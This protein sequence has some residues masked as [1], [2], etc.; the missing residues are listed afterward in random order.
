ML[1]SIADLITMSVFLSI[2]PSVR[3]A[4]S[5]YAR[6]DKKGDFMLLHYMFLSLS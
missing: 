1:L 5:A 2:S 6:G 4:A 3:E